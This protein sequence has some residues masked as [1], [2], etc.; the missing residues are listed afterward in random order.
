M[1]VGDGAAAAA[2]TRAADQ[3]ARESLAGPPAAHCQHLV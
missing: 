2:F 3:S 1:T